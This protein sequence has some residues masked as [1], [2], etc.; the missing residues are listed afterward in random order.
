MSLKAVEPRIDWLIDWLNDW[1]I[2]GG[3]ATSV[4]VILLVVWTTRA[5]LWRGSASANNSQR[6]DSV[7]TVRQEPATWRRITHLDALK[8]R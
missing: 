1:L 3:H 7:G 8:V 4:R 6:A 2:S 5:M